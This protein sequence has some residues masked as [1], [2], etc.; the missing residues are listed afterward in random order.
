MA[1]SCPRSLF[2]KDDPALL[3][4][5][6]QYEQARGDAGRAAAYYRA[7]LDAMGPQ[8]PAE[9]FSHPANPA[10]DTGDPG[11]GNA[12]ARELMRL[13]APSD[14]ST[15]TTDDPDRGKVRREADVSWRD[16][17]RAKAA[18]LGEFDAAGADD[19][20]EALDRLGCLGPPG[21]QAATAGSLIRISISHEY[22]PLSDDGIEEHGCRVDAVA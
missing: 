4:M 5:A 6:A 22:K 7:A 8:S 14:P 18:T 11:R 20:D 21:K 16:G 9:I 19:R 13:L 3:K 2:Y 15:Q 12:P 17:P 10:G 1:A